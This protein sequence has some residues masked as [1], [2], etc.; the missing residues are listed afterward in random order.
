MKIV[1]YPDPNLLQEAA[2]VEEFD[3]ELRE[4]VEEMFPLMY[5]AKGCGLAAPQVAWLLRVFIVNLAGEAGKGEEK[6]YVNPRIVEKRGTVVA[7]EGCLSIPGVTG[8]VRRASWVR[9]EASDLAGK[10]FQEES[11]SELHARVLQHE[12]DH[13]NGIL[14]VSK[15]VPSQQ[16][17]ILKKLREMREGVP[18]GRA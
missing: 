13:L 15:V 2:P 12:L 7:E 17:L 1:L 6:A 14:F 5:E 3:S 16:K 10:T 11:T 9:I 18:A 8:P 4:K